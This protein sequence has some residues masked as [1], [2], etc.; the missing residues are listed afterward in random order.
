MPNMEIILL[1]RIPKLGML[2]DVVSVKPGY[3][4][5]FLLPQGK[6]LRS[7]KENRAVFD[8][9]RAEL[10]EKNE[11]SKSLAE[12]DYDKLIGKTIVQIRS[13]SE[14]GQLY[15]SVT[16]R[17]IAKAVSEQLKIPVKHQQVRISDPMKTTGIF[18]QTLLLH[19]E[20]DVDI[21]INIAISEEE[22]A[23]Q[24]ADQGQ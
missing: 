24:L 12:K 4:R 7:S 14:K 3:A 1:E 20:I 6:A 18:T 9:R 19:P 5:N 13:A 11:A 23:K 10:A 15:G 2:G 22:A 17:D 8:Q 21:A 16:A